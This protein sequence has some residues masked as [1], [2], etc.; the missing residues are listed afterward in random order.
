MWRGGGLQYVTY[1]A[2]IVTFL[3]PTIS[4]DEGNSSYQQEISSS[5][6]SVS[7]S[8]YQQ[9]VTTYFTPE[10]LSNLQDLIHECHENKQIYLHSHDLEQEKRCEYFEYFY[11]LQNELNQRNKPITQSQNKETMLDILDNSYESLF[12]NYILKGR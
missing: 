12:E 1:V 11:Q 5:F 9:H 2:I 6:S 3:L 7:S 4:G 10:Y 8:V